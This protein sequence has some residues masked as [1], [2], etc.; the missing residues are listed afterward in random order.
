MNDDLKVPKVM[1]SVSCK[2][3]I[4]LDTLSESD[5]MAVLFSVDPKTKR[6]TELGR[7]ES[8]K[9]NPNPKFTKTFIVGYK[10]EQIQMYKIGLYDVDSKSNDLRKHDYIGEMFFNLGD[11][12]AAK[13]LTIS[14][15]LKNPLSPQRKNGLCTVVAEECNGSSYLLHM[16]INGLNLDKKDRFGKSDGYL[17]F[18]RK[19]TDGDRWVK[20]HKTEVIK[21]TL[22]PKW[23]KFQLS[24]TVLCG[25]DLSREIKIECYDW[26]KKAESDLI[27]ICYFKI[28]ELDK[29]EY[30]ELEL[31]EPTKKKKKKKYKNS[32]ILQFELFVIEPQPT[33]IGYIRGGCEICT[34][35]A[36]DFTGS[37]GQPEETNSLHYH[38]PYTFND[39]Q[40]GIMTCGGILSS[41]N[42]SQEYPVYGFGAKIDDK[43]SHCFPLNGD[44]VNPQVKGVEG[45][46]EAYNNTFQRK[47]FLLWG[48]T[49]FAPIINESARLAKHLQSFGQKYLVL[50]ILT[51][52][53]ITDME[54]TKKAIVE[55]AELPLS[56]V[57]VGI[58]EGDFTKMEELDGDEVRIAYRGKKASRDIVQFVPFEEVKVLGPDA[59]AKE[60]LE[61]IPDQLLEYYKKN[62]IY[63]KNPL[64]NN[65]N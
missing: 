30:K 64:Q 42:Y 50:L 21:N 39:Y 43:P 28:D 15:H 46:L 49:T 32:G 31:I 47:N 9:D 63:P 51:D 56:I 11:L 17:D 44:K 20:V 33:F 4:S 8:Y 16:K 41:Y 23:K 5:P 60:T 45:I 22:N 10:F 6:V 3:L 52:G 35:V 14:T 25:N 19:Q 55:A 37:N 48:P 57:I 7:T 61:E 40:N 29:M 13:G 62:K 1:L 36:I 65:Q 58:G 26:N 2:N 27:G 54:L 34:I 12:M 59:L 53:A 24:S 18:F 38:D